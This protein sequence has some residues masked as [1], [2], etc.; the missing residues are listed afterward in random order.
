MIKIDPAFSWTIALSVALLFVIAVSHKLRDWSE[1][2]QVVR[3][4]ELLPEALVSLAAGSLIALELGAAVLILMTATR[5][6]GA[7]MSSGLFAV[8]AAAMAINLRRG[9]VNLDCGC[10]GAGRRQPIRWWMVARNLALAVVALS[11]VAQPTARALG[12]LDAV[13][14]GCATLTLAFLYAAQNLLQATRLPSAR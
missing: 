5:P 9:R 13:T 1:F 6:A 11:A 12:A 10:L 2:R 8:Y 3:N 7:A 4:Y 14:I